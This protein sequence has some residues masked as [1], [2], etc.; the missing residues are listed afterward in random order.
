[1]VTIKDF[2]ALR[3][4][5]NLAKD[6]AAL[7]YDV[8]STKEAAEEIKKHPRSF[9]QVDLPAATVD[10]FDGPINDVAVK[11]FE[12]MKGAGIFERDET[13]NMYVYELDDGTRKQRG[14]MCLASVDD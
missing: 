9:L 13:R 12:A 7:P 5:N 10:A 3:P 6:V 8:Y 11:N 2:K 14:L 4:K 1:M